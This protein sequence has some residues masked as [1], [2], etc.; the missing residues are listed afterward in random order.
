MIII[1]C[2]EF[3]C[4][5]IRLFRLKIGVILLWFIKCKLYFFLYEKLKF[6]GILIIFLISYSIVVFI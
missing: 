1:K 5:E 2:F 3:I 4:W 6:Y